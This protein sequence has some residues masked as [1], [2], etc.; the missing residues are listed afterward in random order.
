MCNHHI[1]V[2]TKEKQANTSLLLT[3]VWAMDAVRE[4][5]NNLPY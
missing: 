1:E 2:E 3:V 5:C 4:S